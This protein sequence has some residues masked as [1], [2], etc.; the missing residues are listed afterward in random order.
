MKW[1]EHLRTINH[2][3]KLVR[4]HCFAVGLYR[5][6]LMHD[7][8]KYKPV[9]FLVGARY[10]Q[11]TCSP[12]NAERAAKG[13]SSAWLHH[14][15]RNKHHLEYWIDYSTGEESKM[16]GMKMPVVYVVEMFCDRVAA[17]KTYRR[18]QY[19]QA[20]AYDYYM[21]SKDHYLIHPES[22]SLLEE[23]LIM[24]KDEGEEKT[25]AYIKKQVLKKKK[26]Y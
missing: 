5:Q 22:K 26:V 20:D 21:R 25:F 14:K 3:R 16:C 1:L 13:Y 10:Y 2:H 9:E 7:L 19:T 15:G 11:G 23:L 24:L 18:E 4:Q 6:G 17:S 8:S 12:N